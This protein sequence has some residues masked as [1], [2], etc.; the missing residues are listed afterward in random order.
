MGKNHWILIVFGL[1]FL[2]GCSSK[3]RDNEPRYFT[4]NRYDGLPSLDPAFARNQATIWACHHLYN[5]LVQLDSDLEIKPAL[6]KKWSVSEDGKTY[7]FVLR[8]S[9]FFH[10]HP[11]FPDKA[12]RKVRAQDV[13]Y[14]LG[15]IIDPQVASPGAWIFNDRVRTEQP[16]VALNDSTFQLNLKAP[17]NP[18]LGILSMQYCSIVPQKIV[19]YYGKDFRS[20]P[21]G[22]GAFQFQLWEEGEVLL[23]Q[24]NQEY[25]E[26]NN[27][28]ER[29]P[30]LAGVRIQF[31][32]DKGLE[33]IKF[34][35]QQLDYISDLEPAFSE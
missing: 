18:I 31:F 8:D 14:S 22:T 24:K 2:L 1:F 33:Y 21:V 23:M 27:Q 10:E 35:Q 25:F 26:F 9:V 19:E 20:H 28:G 17:F 30:Y 29:L 16:F 13:A 11:L 15:R 7:T 3:Q 6:A 12:D 34:K 5:S 4:Y 32:L